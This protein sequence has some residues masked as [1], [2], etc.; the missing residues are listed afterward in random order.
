MAERVDSTETLVCL[1]NVQQPM[2]FSININ[3]LTIKHKL[4]VQW[5]NKAKLIR[6]EALNA[7]KQ[8]QTHSAK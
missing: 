7:D 3:Q 6:R 4:L 8:K 2:A 5:E 1:L